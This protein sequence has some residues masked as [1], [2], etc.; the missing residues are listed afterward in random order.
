[1]GFRVVAARRAQGGVRGLLCVGVALAVAVPLGV[2]PP[3]IAGEVATVNP[4]SATVVRGGEVDVFVLVNDVLGTPAVEGG[5]TVA[6]LTNPSAGVATV[7]DTDGI[8]PEPAHIHYVAASGAP[9]GVDGFEYAVSEGTTVVGS[10]TVSVEVLNAAPTAVE[11]VAEVSSAAGA[12]VAIPV[13]DNDTD[14]DGEVLQVVAVHRAS[15]GAATLSG[16]V[17]VYDPEDDFVGLDTFTYTLSD[18]QGGRATAQVSVTV[19]DATTPMVIRAD[20]VSAL[21][22]VAL[23]IDVL[24]ND[25][26]GG[27]DPLTVETAGPSVNGG[28]VIVNPDGRTVTFTAAVAFA[29]QDTFPY[30]VR[31]RRGN[32]AQGQVDVLVAAPVT[33]APPSP[34]PPVV[35]PVAPPV[36]APVDPGG[37]APQVDISVSGPLTRK[38]VPYSYRPGC[39]VGPGSLRRM[40]MNYWDYAGKV[41]RGSLIV[42]VDSVRDLTHVFSRAFAKGFPIKKLNP[43]DVYYKKGRRS[44]TASDRA[45]MAAGNTSAFNCRPV[46]GNPTKRSAH[47]YGVAIDINTFENPYVVGHGFYP[48]AAG[49]YLRRTPCRK[50]MICPGGPV[51]SAMRE[52]GWQWGARWSRPDYQ[53]FSSNGG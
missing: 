51:A 33:P 15:H 35:P 27:R 8:G 22:G 21:A 41:R 9:L 48:R 23:V 13:L 10:A 53:H 25:D 19:R 5:V 30:S 7:V 42:R 4:D 39:P 43:T 32:T 45:A 16:G 11:D 28:S 1:M 20:A 36:V 31:D 47:S 14:P 34:E 6:L 49:K 38:D 24:G 37:L 52:R 2:G 26:G 12:T 3:A 40:T 18:E 44:P 50:G 29:G 17:V 46:V